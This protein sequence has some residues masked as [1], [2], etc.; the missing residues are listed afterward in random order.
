VTGFPSPFDQTAAGCDGW[1]AMYPRHALFNDDRRDFDEG[2]FW[3]QES[4][5]W[6]EP[7][8]PF[9]A[10]VVEC[11]FVGLNQ[12]NA[13]LFAI[14]PSLGAEYRLLNGYVYNS[15]SLITDPGTLARRAELF[16]RRGGHY[17]QHWDDLYQ[18]WVR[19]VERAIQELEG[20]EV[21]GLPEIE[22][23]S[24]VTEARG[25]G[26]SHSLIRAYSRLLEGMDRVVHYHFEFLNLGYVAFAGLYQLCRDAFPDINDETV[27]KLVSGID[28]LPL[29]PD[30]ELKRL[31]RLAIALEIAEVVRSAHDEEQLRSALAATE[32]G[33]RWLR[34][35]EAAKDPWFCF[36]F[37]NG[38][39]SDQR[40]WID[41]PSF[42]I[43]TIS[44]YV[45][46]L[47]AGE[48]IARPQETLVAERDRITAEYRALLPQNARPAFDANLAL[49]RTVFPYVEN[50]SFY[51]DHWYFTLFWNK[52]REFGALLASEGFLEESEDI[53]YLRH[54]EVRAALEELRVWWSGGGVAPATG[55]AHWPRVVMGRKSIRAA[56][57]RWTAPVALGKAPEA[58]TDPVL[59]ML[60]GITT[61]SLREWLVGSQRDA[62]G[63]LR[64][65]PGSPGVAEG[66][67]RLILNPAQ[68]GELEE[69]EILVA[70]NTSPSWTAGFSR[71]V[72]A[73][74]DI[75]GVMSHAAIVAREYGL[76]AVVGTGNATRTIRTGDRVRVDGGSG[77]VTIVKTSKDPAKH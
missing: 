10:L 38:L 50:H 61:E 57:L 69:G 64:G 51:I 49:A 76:P 26:S 77:A 45:E 36:S 31:A 25:Y 27:A 44:S 53:F 18:A 40:S 60:F 21:P 66:S 63:Q 16:E 4:M 13:R 68:L 32:A 74:L 11:F 55:S 62:G 39:A 71:A 6:P 33:A 23:E 1:E 54:D 35:F 42:A 5:H 14:P 47:E 75:G 15:P 19:K 3:F 20:L 58:I 29:R 65:I 67:A 9:D 70:P 52:V 59:V 46:L 2:R 17:F 73:V 22:A 56:Q 48:D 43:A 28:V 24:V 72:A 34:E 30:E 7:L 8:R 37:G 41:N 12:A